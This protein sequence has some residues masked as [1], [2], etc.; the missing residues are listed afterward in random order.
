[1][2]QPH[3]LNLTVIKRNSALFHGVATAM[4]GHII[5]IDREVWIRHLL[6]DGALQPARP[7]RRVKKEAASLIRIERSKERNSL[8]VVPMKMGKKDVRTNGVPVGLLLDTLSQI[9]EPGAA[10]KNVK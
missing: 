7:V 8:N 4:S 6:L 10:I 3:G 5:H 2:V 9:P 1:M